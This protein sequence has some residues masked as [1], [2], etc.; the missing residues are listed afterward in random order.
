MTHAGA[1]TLL[2]ALA[3]PSFATPTVIN[4]VIN[5]TL[6]HGHQFEMVEELERRGNIC[7]TRDCTAD[8]TVEDRATRL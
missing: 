4:G 3:V 6:V 1:C 5:P 7:V 2:E 8:W